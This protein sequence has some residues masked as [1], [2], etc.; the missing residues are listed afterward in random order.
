MTLYIKTDGPIPEGCDPT[1]NPVPAPWEGGAAQQHYCDNCLGIDPESCMFNKLQPINWQ[2]HAE[3]LAEALRALR[4]AK[5]CGHDFHC[6][7]P[8]DAATAALAAF[9]QAKGI[10][11]GE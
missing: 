7:C 10:S 11:R 8:D 1:G 3:A 4:G 2:A 9:D 6:I 5:T